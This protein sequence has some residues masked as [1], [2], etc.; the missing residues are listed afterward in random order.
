MVD[1]IIPEGF[2]QKENQDEIDKGARFG[3]RDIVL[4]VDILIYR[5][6][7]N[8]LPTQYNSSKHPPNVQACLVPKQS[9]RQVPRVNRQLVLIYL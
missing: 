7:R 3:I 4:E 6:T 8:L 9:D 2:L 1:R 5:P